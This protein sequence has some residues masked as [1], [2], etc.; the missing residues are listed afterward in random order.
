MS[1]KSPDTLGE[2][3]KQRS[4]NVALE[5]ELR[6]AERQQNVAADEN[7]ELFQDNFQNMK[8]NLE[9]KLELANDVPGS[10][11]SEFLDEMVKDVTKMQQLLN[12][13]SMYLPS[14]WIKRAQQNIN[15]LNDS[16]QSSVKDLQPKRKFG[17]KTKKKAT[18]VKP[19]EEI[20]T[21]EP[22]YSSCSGIND[23]ISLADKLRQKNFFGFKDKSEEVLKMTA[24]ELKDRQL[25]L[26]NLVD[27]KVIAL[28]NPSSLQIA[29]L[30]NTTVLIGPTSRSAFIKNCQ[31]CH[32][33]LACQQVRIHDCENVNFY[34]HVTGSAIIEGCRNLCF[35]PYTLDYENKISDFER[36][37]LNPSIN[38]WDKVEDFNWLNESEQSPNFKNLQESEWVKNW[39]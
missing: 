32:F 19:I 33:V 11:T 15:E 4:E 25:H 16:V 5:A 37:G 7:T 8:E 29:G 26:Q 6:K 14:F 21:S 24:D 13:A 35:A 36:S 2:R 17:F 10:K 28:G 12:E 9:K 30:K 38:R 31:G 39:L 34:L 20:D 3:I 18:E 22:D 27:C 1:I 23:A